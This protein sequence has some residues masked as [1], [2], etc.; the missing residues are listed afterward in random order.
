[1]DTIVHTVA[2]SPLRPRNLKRMQSTS[3]KK[4]VFLEPSKIVEALSRFSTV[5][6]QLIKDLISRS[7]TDDDHDVLQRYAMFPLAQNT[8]CPSSGKILTF[9]APIDPI[10]KKA[11][12]GPIFTGHVETDMDSIGGS[13]A[14]AELYGG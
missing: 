2:G 4:G 7:E 13:I 9:K 10:K 1:M 11:A 14:A 12:P 8:V 3:V 6:E 5:N